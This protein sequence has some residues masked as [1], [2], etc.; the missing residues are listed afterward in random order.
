MGAD[1][2]HREAGAAGA[3]PSAWARWLLPTP[4]GPT[5]RTLSWRSTKAQVDTPPSRAAVPPASLRGNTWGEALGSKSI[6]QRE[7]FTC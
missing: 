4:V 6:T 7:D 5:T 3:W 1:V 2:G